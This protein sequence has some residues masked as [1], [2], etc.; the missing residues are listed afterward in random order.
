MAEGL[1][2]GVLGGEE[3]KIDPTVS[4][5]EPLAVA[6]ATNLAN[7]NADV[8]AETV[9]FLREQTDLLRE[10]K[11]NIRAEY[12]FFESEAGPRLLALRL[13]TGFQLFFALIATVIGLALAI[14]VWSATR[15]RSVVIDPF[16][17]PPALAADGLNGKVVASGLLD[18]LTEIQASSQSSIE[19]R[20]LKN[21]WTSEISVDVP[22]TGIS[23][24][25]LERMVKIRFGHDQHIEG[26]L[27]RSGPGGLALTVRGNG[28]MPK[29]FSGDAGAL[30]KLLTQS[31]EYL[32]SQSQPGL[33]MSYLTQV[34]RDDE[35]IAFAQSAY[36]T[37]E[38]SERLY[39]L[40]G[41]GNAITDKGGEGAMA[42]ALP[43]YR[44]AVK[45]KPD[46]WA[47]YNNI[48]YALAGLGDEEGVVRTGEQ[49]MKVAGGRPGRSPESNYEN[50]DEITWDLQAE[51][52]SNIA[53]MESYGGIGSLLAR[54]GAENLS[55]A[56]L[57]VQLH[58][59][60]ATALRLQT[61]PIDAKNMP[62]VTAGAMDKAL[63][64][65][66]TGDLK[67]AA[68]EWDVFAAAYANPTIATSNPK[69]ICNAA[70]TYEKTDQPAKADS[71]LKPYGGR[72]YVDCYRFK[73]DVLDLRGDW[74]GAQDWYARAVK[75]APSLPAGY[76]SWGLALAKHGDLAG[77]AEK[78]KLA[79]EKGPH[80]A[81][82]LKAWGD[83]LM[84]QGNTR[85]ALAK[86]DEALKYAPNWKQLKEAR[87]AAAKIKI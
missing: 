36:N 18:V 1:L 55:V 42:Q 56:Q 68:H 75:L 77:A 64:A 8:A 71:A 6:I 69:Y 72:T 79:N 3:E 44:E 27:I 14:V 52:A 22:D 60:E 54:N 37:V 13:R 12:E 45:L 38:A 58:D 87:E 63:H 49:M 86:Y 82:P 21:A 26:D 29:T 70:V 50:Y 84:R 15:S 85:E 73:G 62:D 47:G 17:V 81:D 20:E 23:L 46:Y 31:G 7:Q 67:E 76:Y 30:D 33:W 59:P 24:N 40:N 32:F 9:T 16:E 48:M 83:V 34:G 43:L 65:E 25:E 74:A 19:H 61:T 66:E 80:W 4:G 2:E 28:I 57:D 41:L 10:Q 5:A 39:V 53:D 51:R 35:A 78:L 11:K